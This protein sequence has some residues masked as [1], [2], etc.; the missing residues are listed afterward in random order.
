MT[1]KEFG[2]KALEPIRTLRGADMTPA[3]IVSKFIA[4]AIRDIIRRE[5]LSFGHRED[6][7]WAVRQLKAALDNPGTDSWLA[8][9]P[10]GGDSVRFYNSEVKHA[11]WQGRMSAS[12]FHRELVRLLEEGSSGANLSQAKME[13]LTGWQT[14]PVPGESRL[15]RLSR[16]LE[17]EGAIRIQ[18]DWQEAEPIL[19]FAF[20]EEKNLIEPGS[21]VHGGDGR[22]LTRTE[23]GAK[24][25]QIRFAA[26]PC[27]HFFD[28]AD[29]IDLLEPRSASEEARMVRIRQLRE[30][31]GEADLPVIDLLISS[32]PPW[33]F[34]F[35]VGTWWV[36]GSSR[37]PRAFRGIS[38]F[39]TETTDPRQ[40]S[41]IWR[42]QLTILG[43]VPRY[44]LHRLRDI[45][46]LV[47]V[48]DAAI[49]ARTA[50]GD[51]SN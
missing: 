7:Y 49:A 11:L 23:E 39:L 43:R 12:R 47:H 19:Y 29:Q 50:P 5:M 44:W 16:W 18:H 31:F 40:E 42:Q 51:A 9:L 4:L 34:K 45:F 22:V 48:A 27:T 10:K 32:P 26:I 8:V 13:Q 14:W 15:S 28:A 1:R 37:S 38:L 33:N 35:R 6:R 36:V 3:A 25:T 46:S 2:A 24:L 20:V 17:R 21:D 41:E 30:N